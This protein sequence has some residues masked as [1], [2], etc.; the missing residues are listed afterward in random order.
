MGQLV[1]LVQ[2]I[3][4]LYFSEISVGVESSPDAAERLVTIQTLSNAVE[5]LEAFDETVDR[6][7]R[8]ERIYDIY[9]IFSVVYT[10]ER[11]LQKLAQDILGEP[12]PTEPETALY[13]FRIVRRLLS[14]PVDL[15]PHSGDKKKG[16]LPAGAV[17]SEGIWEADTGRPAFLI[18]ILQEGYNWSDNKY[19]PFAPHKYISAL[20]SDLK[21]VYLVVVQSRMISR[22]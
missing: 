3:R 14:H 12:F 20:K 17:I 19:R 21:D 18:A 22:L 9:A 4:S 13:E 2:Q 16:F 1:D 5:A 8:G 11:A 10:L 15:T 6:E 7:T